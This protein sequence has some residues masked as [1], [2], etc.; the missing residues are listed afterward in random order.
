MGVKFIMH[1]LIG[2]R[3]QVFLH[4]KRYPCIISPPSTLDNTKVKVE[5]LSWTP[6]RG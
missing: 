3:W 2:E 4:R 5:M 1:N 6:D